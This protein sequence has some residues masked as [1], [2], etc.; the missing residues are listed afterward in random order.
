M[1]HIRYKARVARKLAFLLAVSLVI[2]LADQWTK[3][4]VLRDLTGRFHGLPTVGERLSAMYA[5][6]PPLGSDGLHFR[7]NRPI[8]VF[9]RFLRL[10]YAENPGAAW[11]LFRNLS[12]KVRGPFFHVVSIAAII[13]I[14]YYFFRLT[15]AREE[16]WAR[17]GLPLVLGGA[18]GNYMDRL[19]RAFVIDFIEAHWMDKVAWPS[20]NVADSA[21]CVGVGMLILDSFVRREPKPTR[22]S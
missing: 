5:S 2:V 18:L 22:A 15:G 16:K 4:L 11:G 13:L 21:I 8:T 7:P 20:F 14:T 1:R 3:Y 9:E 17:L 12:E 10:R 6:P 19:S